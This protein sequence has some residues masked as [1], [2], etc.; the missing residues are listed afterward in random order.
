MKTSPFIGLAVLACSPVFAIELPGA[1]DPVRPPSNSVPAPVDASPKV[2]R[3]VPPPAELSGKT[4]PL[5]ESAPLDTRIAYLGVG[6]AQVPGILAEHLKLPEGSGVVVRSL[7]P[8]GPAASVG[9]L[10]ND[11]ITKL[12]GKSVGSHDE[13]KQVVSSH[14]PGDKISITYLHEGEPKSSELVLGS[15]SQAVRSSNTMP[16][17][18]M[19]HLLLDGM[20]QDQADRV[21]QAIKQH[22]NDL[23][24]M[25]EQFNQT[26]L[27]P[28]DLQNRVQQMLQNGSGSASATETQSSGTVRVMD[29]QGS[30]ELKSVNGSKT[31]RALDHLGNVVWEGPFNSEEDRKKMPTDVR[32][33]FDRLNIDMDFGGGGGLRFHFKSH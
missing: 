26:P 8:K 7:D 5:E 22:M 19:D 18:P 6:G 11:I 4:L 1:K 20:P 12:D 32:A 25:E 28:A 2:A 17:V 15:T 10:E 21:R 16:R 14:K 13:M 27:D 9:L 3:E 23:E 30:I 24:K 29:D 33:R 31:V